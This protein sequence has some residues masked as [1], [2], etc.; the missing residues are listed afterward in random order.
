[1]LPYLELAERLA[2]RGH[3]VSYVSTARN[4]ARLPPLRRHGAAGG[5]HGG[6]AVDLV[7]L[8]LPRVDGL[9]EGAESTNDVPGD[10]LE[11]LWKAFDTLAAPLADY[12]AAACAA[13]GN[14]KP[15]WVLTDTFHHWAPLI[16]GEHGVPSAM[17]LP[18]AAMIAS[19][20][21]AGRDH[22]ELVAASVF[23]HPRSRATDGDTALRVARECAAWELDAF[24]LAAALIGKPLVPLGLLPPS[25]DGGRAAAAAH[26]DDDDAV[27]WLDLQ[28]PKSVVYVALGSE[29][30]L[31]VELVHELAL[32]LEL[33]RT[34]FLWALR[35]PRDVA[36][37][38]VLHGLG[39]NARFMEGRKVGLM[40]A[41]NED[42]GSFDCRGIAS[43]VRGVMVEEG[44]RKIFVE[45]AKKVQ[46]I[47]ADKELQERYV[48]EFVQRLRSYMSGYG[49][50]SGANDP[51]TS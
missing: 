18:T 49:K 20:A 24:S 48:D 3:R 1:M 44:S 26:G 38:D 41:R 36:D 11:P 2:S 29:V 34:R 22:A 5:D 51:T 42:D 17:L 8:K 9:P 43:A 32:G 30:P 21:G 39:R 31:R 33:A 37:A 4:L 23:E 15:D 28:P 12:L 25:P 19:L 6:G 14:S 7:P 40:V 16:A 45:N 46:Q 35:K 27:R 50:P 13:G 10:K 47:V